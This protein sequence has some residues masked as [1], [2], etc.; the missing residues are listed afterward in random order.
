MNVTSL[1]RYQMNKIIY[2][3]L[4][5]LLVFCTIACQNKNTPKQNKLEVIAS[6]DK[7]WT[8]VAVDQTGRI[9]VN[10]P[11]W[12]DDVPMSV[13]EIVNGK[14]VVYPNKD[15]N[16]TVNTESF[17]AVQSVVV[18]KKNR[19]WILDT[20]NPLFKGVMEGG[21]LLYQFNLESN[22]K[23][24]VYQF[25]EGEY[26]PNSYF[27]DVRID[28][29]NEIAYMT[30]S[31]DGA[32]ITLDLN[33]GTSRR[34]LD[35]HPS[36][37]SE[38]NYL[39]CNGERWENSVH[40]DGIALSPDNEYLY[41]IALTGHTLYRINTGDLL[42]KDLTNE[43]L[44]TKV[45]TVK[46]IPATDGMLFDKSGNLWL[47]GLENNSINKINTKGDL[48]SVVQ[49]SSIRWADSFAED[50]TGNIYFTTSQIHL[51]NERRGSYEVIRFDPKNLKSK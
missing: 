22:Q 43:A 41:Y 16:N 24:K 1:I 25:L 30:D 32:I 47:G 6:S 11:K 50:Q 37:N 27:N 13:A 7:Q 4:I 20:R 35:Q 51:P 15:W 9:F 29:D 39:I 3:L 34:L 23:E 44:A 40:S 48:T 8:G 14:P 12:S 49:D 46:T 38:V 26:K 2:K 36:T 10:Y 5:V 28:T 21:P 18:D 17:V 19:L 31:G 45:E 33:T 42:N